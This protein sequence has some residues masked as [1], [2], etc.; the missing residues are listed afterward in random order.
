[1]TISKHLKVLEGNDSNMAGFETETTINTSSSSVNKDELIVNSI[2]KT[3]EILEEIERDIDQDEKKGTSSEDVANMIEALM[4]NSPTNS[5]KKTDLLSPTEEAL[6][7]INWNDE[8]SIENREV[9]D[10]DSSKLDTSKIDGDEMQLQFQSLSEEDK[11]ADLQALIMNQ[12]KT[13]TNLTKL[14]AELTQ[15]NQKHQAAQEKNIQTYKA[16]LDELQKLNLDKVKEYESKLVSIKSLLERKVRE[17]DENKMFYDRYLE[18]K[19]ENINELK[20][21]NEQLQALIENNDVAV[22]NY[23]L[24]NAVREVTKERKKLAED[25]MKLRKEADEKDDQ[26]TTKTAQIELLQNNLGLAAKELKILKAMKPAVEGNIVDGGNNAQS[27][28]GG[29]SSGNSKNKGGFTLFDKHVVKPIRG[30]G[31]D[32]NNFARNNLLVFEKKAPEEKV[33]EK[34]KPVMKEAVKE[35]KEKITGLFGFGGNSE[36]SKSSK[37]KEKE[38][39]SFKKFD[40]LLK[41]EKVVKEKKEKKEKIEKEKEGEGE[42]MS[43][44]PDQEDLFDMGN[45]QQKLRRLTNQG[46]KAGSKNIKSL[47]SGV[48]NFF[49]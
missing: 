48:K 22:R 21:Q 45:V 42:G 49:S 27:I 5:D 44:E 18:E 39:Q 6:N 43:T 24:E 13:I 37:N 32:A 46:V 15:I 33:E 11:V 16:K 12:R 10:L 31:G 47:V 41:K 28:R 29:K 35:V 17:I 7:P 3:I 14:N 8:S 4:K 30:G 2:Q 20:D 25:I 26:I 36:E 38:D 23:E 40:D 34:E 1:M 9:S 19:T